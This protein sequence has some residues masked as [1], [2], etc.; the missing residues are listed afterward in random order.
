MSWE[1]LNLDSLVATMESGSRPKGGVSSDRGDI[2]SIGGENILSSGGVTLEV[3]KLVPAAFYRRMTKGRLMSED[4]LINKDGAQTGKVGWY[5]VTD[6]GPACIN[7][8]VFLLRGMP[9]RITQGYL[10]YTLLSEVGQS[11]IWRQITG[12]AQPGLKRGFTKG[13]FVDIPTALPE[14]DKIVEILSAVDRAI[15]SNQ[16]SIAKQ[17]RVR[18]GLMHDLLARGI[19]EHGEVRSEKSHEFKDSSFGRI[20]SGYEVKTLGQITPRDAPIG[21]GI[22]QPGAYDPAGVKVAGIFTINSEFKRWHRSSV[23]IERAYVRSRIQPG[24]VLLSIKGTTG[25]VGVVPDEVYG[26]I[27]RDIARIRPAA[28]VNPHYLRF[29]MLSDFFQ[30]YLLNAE[31]GTTRAELSI[32]I[33][34]ELQI[35]LPSKS[36]QDQVASRLSSAE[37]GIEATVRAL[38]KLEALKRALMQDLL[39]GNRRVAA[40]MKNQGRSSA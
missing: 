32:K 27:S 12:S 1:R 28:T 8:H 3:V 19:D 2:P 40:C 30:R 16:T 37:Q 36:E 9:Q 18:S 10:Y 25:R 29:L 5:R 24:D 39:S 4:V 33:L 26:N 11:Q 14:Q 22:V 15:E 23:K 20:P 31:V 7:E 38:I 6:S 21:Y 34:R 35:S 13:V 17:K